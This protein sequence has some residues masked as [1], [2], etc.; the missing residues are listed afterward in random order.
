MPKSSL[1]FF[2]GLA[3]V[4]LLSSCTSP[5]SPPPGGEEPAVTH[6]TGLVYDSVTGDPVQ[7]VALRFGE[8]STETGVDGSFIISLGES[9]ET[10]VA[11]WLVFKEGYEFIYVDRVSIASS[12]NRQLSF[13]IKKSDPSSYPTVSSLQGDLSYADG[14][15]VPDASGFWIDIYGS[16]GTYSHYEGTS[17]GPRYSIDTTEDSS[18]CLV[19]LR[20]NPAMGNDFVVMAQAVNLS[21]ISPVELDFQEPDEGFAVV[22]AAASQGGN[23]GSCIFATPYGFIPGWFKADGADPEIREGWEFSS[24]A[25]EEVL[26]YN[27]FHWQ[28]V[29]WI[30]S[31]EDGAFTGLPDHH[32]LFMSSTVLSTFSDTVS[33]PSVDRALGPDEGADPTSLELNGAALSLDLV[34]RASLY[35]FSFMED[36]EGG[37]TLG[38]V[39]SFD[40]SVMLPDLLIAELGGRSIRVS[41]DVMDSHITALDPDLLGAG[42]G[43]PPDLDIG[44]VEGSG[45]ASYER[46]FEVPAPGGIIIG[47]E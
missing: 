45:A 9:G 39:L 37:E 33:L 19:I 44:M 38:T 12:S 2:T 24:A 14:G 5:T 11:D 32:K 17:S 29:F 27:P 6:L 31:E 34:A 15:P 47:I 40:C 7:G 18:D 42:G 20:V 36:A 26:V 13:P 10:L 21:G 35:S 16:D 30:Q 46:Q 41:F 4:L 23:R 8:R 43:F 25:T 1:S 3:V 22:Q 28:Q